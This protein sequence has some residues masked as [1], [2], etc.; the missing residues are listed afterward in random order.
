M[1]REVLT[2]AGAT[3]FPYLTRF[4]GF[5]RA[6]GTALAL[7]I[8]HRVSVH[9]DPFPDKEIERTLLD[10][11]R[12]V[13]SPATDIIPLVNNRDELTVLATAVKIAFLRYPFP[14][15]FPLVFYDDVP[16]LSVREI[17]ATKAYTIGR[18]SSFKDYIDPYFV[19]AENRATLAGII[20]AAEQKF[21][22]D[23][24]SRLF[25]EQLVYVADRDDTEVQFLNP[26]VTPPQVR[27]FFESRIRDLGTTL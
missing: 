20:A 14:A 9:Y 24:N 15:R 5:Y 4:T 25:L 27:A 6:G 23:F 22:V 12:R 2:E 8:G 18:R 17:A 3:L 11:V 26:P 7:Q 19:V 16:L 21:G 13:F 10:R 1:H